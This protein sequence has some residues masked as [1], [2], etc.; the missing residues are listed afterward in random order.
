MGQVTG[1]VVGAQ[2]ILGVETLGLE[3]VGPLVQD[4]PV[5][6][7]EVRVALGL[8]QGRQEDEH[9]AGFLDRHLV[10]LGPL[11]AAVDLAVGQRI[12]AEIVRGEGPLPAR[13]GCVV[14]VLH[15]DGLGQGRAEQQKLRSHRINYIDRA[16]TAVGEILLGEDQRRA[17]GVGDDLA[18]REGLTVRQPDDPGILRAAQAIMSASSSSSSVRQR[19]CSSAYSAAEAW[20][21][22]AAS[23]PLLRQ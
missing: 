16:D 19:S 11:A 1:E 14:E 18:A 20:R 6:A 7:G 10:F 8:G 22:S 21:R 13:R 12:G 23:Q 3:I 9:V 2:L 15:E 4:R 5:L 17:G